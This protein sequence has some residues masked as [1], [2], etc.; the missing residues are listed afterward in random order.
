MVKFDDKTK[1][2]ITERY[3]KRGYSLAQIGR[4]IESLEN[5]VEKQKITEYG[6]VKVK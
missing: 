5:N 6:E 2:E 3:Q 1:E 4:I